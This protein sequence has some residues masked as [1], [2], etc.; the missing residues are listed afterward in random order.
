[1][2]L[3]YKILYVVAGLPAYLGIIFLAA[4]GVSYFAFGS[5]VPFAPIANRLFSKSGPWA[6]IVCFIMLLWVFLGRVYR[7]MYRNGAFK[8]KAHF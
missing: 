2:K 6:L 7:G 3:R 5:L 8:D 1:M 4:L